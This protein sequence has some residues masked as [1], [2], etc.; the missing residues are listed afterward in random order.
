MP[1]F[2][3]EAPYTKRNAYRPILKLWS[4]DTVQSC[5]AALRTQVQMLHG[6][7]DTCGVELCG[8]GLDA[9]FPG[10]QT[11]QLPTLD[12]LRHH[13]QLLRVTERGLQA[14]KKRVANLQAQRKQ[15]HPHETPLRCMVLLGCLLSL[16]M[17]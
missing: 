17:Q 7:H 13:V 1:F 14:Q 9:V 8:T 12:Q 16:L 4:E 2:I 5:Q 3:A 15:A 11:E 6:S 10:Q